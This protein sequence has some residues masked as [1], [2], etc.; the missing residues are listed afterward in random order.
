MKQNKRT[1]DAKMRIIGLTGPT[2]SGKSAVSAVLKDNGAVIVDADK[3]A[4]DIILKGEAAYNELLGYFGEEIL[5]NEKEIDRKK[6]GQIVFSQ[7]GEKL[8]FLN[9]CTHKHIFDKMKAEIETAEKS[10][11]EITV[12]DAP[13]LIEGK[14]ITLCK[15]VWVVFADD[16]SRAERIMKRDLI[17]YQQALDRMSKQKGYDVYNKYADIIIDNSTGLVNL[18]RQVENI[19]N[20]TGDKDAI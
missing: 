11:F 1:G 8:D 5:N 20:K 10:G 14:F 9:K 2:G 18:K 12:L 13:L 17:T 4:H 19:L 15:E 6:L 16:E 7:G 3:I